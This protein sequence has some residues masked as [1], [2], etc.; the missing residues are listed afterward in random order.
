MMTH[1]V[2]FKFESRDKQIHEEAKARLLSMEGVVPA[3]K[4]IEVGLN[5]IDGPR[6]FDL[7]LITRFDDL[8]GLDAYREHPAHLEV[9]SY[10]K[11][12]VAQSVAVDYTGR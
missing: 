9:L 5:E 4:S 8:A 12:V 7:S 1:V 11:T 6:A 3:L 2:L 10:L